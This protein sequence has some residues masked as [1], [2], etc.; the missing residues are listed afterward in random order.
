MEDEISNMGKNLSLSNEEVSG[1]E[2]PLG[3]W[4]TDSELP[5]FCA[6]GR[7]LSH[8][9]FHFDSFRSTITTAFNPIR[10]M[11]MKM[12][13]GN[14]ILFRFDHQIDRKRVIDNSPWAFDKN[15][16]VIKPVAAE[17][18]PMKVDL[19][20]CDFHTHI[21]DFPLGKMTKEIAKFIENQIGGFID[22]ESDNNNGIWGSSLRIRVSLNITKP[23]KRVLR[24][25]T[26]MGED[27][28]ISFT[29]EKLPNFC[30]LCGCLGHL[31]KYCELQL[32]TDFVD[33]GENMPYGP[34][35]IANQLHSI[36]K[37]TAS[38][39]Q[40]RLLKWTTHAFF[41][42]RSHYESTLGKQKHS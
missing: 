35:L 27:Q 24:I 38:I 4:H 13:D 30:Y 32:Q 17:E 8:K 14:R 10:P 23:L 18:N 16:L 41:F 26:S 39:K 29:Y 34:W 3:L 37:P 28:L 19:D 22:V 12:I 21:H 6:V 36:R 25:R 1:V 5:G 7:L 2:I 20:W 31:A 9:S 40:N 15:L 11:D 33:P 42:Y